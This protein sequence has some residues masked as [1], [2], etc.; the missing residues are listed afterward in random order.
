MK[1]ALALA[2][3]LTGCLGPE[4]CDT[5]YESKDAY[6]G[7]RLA[8]GQDLVAV[9]WY[10][11]DSS[12]TFAALVSASGVISQAVQLPAGLGRPA[13]AL[14][15]RAMQA[16]TGHASAIWMEADSHQITTA[17]VGDHDVWSS[18]IA[19]VI[20]DPGDQTGV[21]FDGHTYQMFW[22]AGAQLMHEQVSEQGL[23]GGVD[24]LGAAGGSAPALFAVTDGAGAIYVVVE[25]GSTT[26]VLSFDPATTS[27]RELWSGPDVA[28]SEAFW[29]AGEL[30]LREDAYT[31]VLHSF[32]PATLQW[33]DHMMPAEVAGG[34][35]FASPTT[36]YAQRD[37]VYELDPALVATRLGFPLGEGVAG[38]LGPDWI[39][40]ATYGNGN[41]PIAGFVELSRGSANTKDPIWAISIAVDSPPIGSTACGHG[42]S[43]P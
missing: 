34:T 15:G 35:L 24:D 25:D 42:I 14:S 16:T 38:T 18:V 13:Y 6:E 2:C 20:G 37:Q 5:Y 3:A 32:D 1:I 39:E 21:V 27:T 10:R 31:D 33:R 19:P 8:S 9:T 41:T 7:G 4:H 28:G 12:D 43:V 26:R 11:T 36:L 30:H 29:F 17:V 23:F 40:L 22:F